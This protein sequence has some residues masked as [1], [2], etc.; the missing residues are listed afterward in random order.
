MSQG[1]KIVPLRVQGLAKPAS[2]TSSAGISS[3]KRRLDATGLDDEP[4]TRALTPPSIKQK[5]QLALNETSRITGG[6]GDTTSWAHRSL[7]TYKHELP[8]LREDYNRMN[9][10]VNF[11]KLVGIVLGDCFQ[12]A[13]ETFR[14][15]IEHESNAVSILRGHA[16]TYTEAKGEPSLYDPFRDFAN[17]LFGF[18]GLPFC[19]LNTSPGPRPNDR[20][21]KSNP[22]RKP[23]IVMVHKDHLTP[24]EDLTTIDIRAFP[25]SKVVLCIEFKY[26]KEKM[27]QK[28]PPG[29]TQTKS[30]SR[31]PK[32]QTGVKLD[33]KDDR[34][35]SR[36][37]THV[38]SMRS[39]KGKS[40]T[41]DSP[42]MQEQLAAYAIEMFSARGVRRHVLGLYIDSL[43]VEFWYYDRSAGYGS[44]PCPFGD[45]WE[46]LA[47]LLLA[48]GSASASQLGFEPN[49][50]PPCDA[51]LG[52][53][54]SI[55]VKAAG[56]R[57]EVNGKEYV[58]ENEQLG[59]ARSL[60][61][62][63]TAVFKVKESVVNT[64]QASGTGSASEGLVVKLSWQLKDRRSEADVL[65]LLRKKGIPSVPEIVSS[66]ELARMQ[67]GTHG[68][69]QEI[70]NLD[71]D[72]DDRIYR[73]IVMKPFLVHLTTIADWTTFF[74]LF[75]G[76]INVH[77][78]IYTGADILHRDINP[79]NLM[80]KMEA[81]G[82]HVPFLIDYDFAVSVPS[83]NDTPD[84]VPLADDAPDDRILT[85]RTM[86]TPFLALELLSEQPPTAL[87]RH[88]LESF[89]YC[90]WWISVSYCEGI[91][92]RTDQL[93][94]WC[95]GSWRSIRYFKN[96]H[97][98]VRAVDESVFTTNMIVRQER[99]KGDAAPFEWESAGGIITWET[100]QSCLSPH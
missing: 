70:L 86:A 31:K 71:V 61:G 37:A 32:F 17:E 64:M 54:S 24:G 49:I 68:R 36:S 15:H 74:E 6:M 22:Q 23:D 5:I 63:G 99:V 85:H 9:F 27:G 58:V 50:K 73:A 97:M 1:D 55:L 47:I 94:G 29:T 21:D 19:F 69:V 35:S 100:F 92:I 80:V 81:D 20:P 82:K 16:Q 10:S 45:R 66:E 14:R 93:L 39:E 56:A 34:R 76:L 46:S 30:R 62:R 48:I 78:S 41:G 44:L 79:E 77:R 43:S 12:T 51:K 96:G 2:D 84:G 11:D 52:L 60:T 26:N 83:A 89:L 65:E 98:N 3:I 25:W 40:R 59:R 42:Q 13:R 88:D 33:T 67:H 53:S 95:T 8:Y 4:S 75:K 90:L 38:D 87:Y 57:I 7:A 91:Q 18:A 72:R 28:G